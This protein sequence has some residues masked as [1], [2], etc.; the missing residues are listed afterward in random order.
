MTIDDRTGKPVVKTRADIERCFSESSEGKDTAFKEK[1]YAVKPLVH[2]QNVFVDEVCEP[3]SIRAHATPKVFEAFA[4]QYEPAEGQKPER[5]PRPRAMVDVPWCGER[6]DVWADGHMFLFGRA[7]RR[8][9]ADTRAECLRRARRKGSPY[10]EAGL[11][12]K[13]A[14]KA[15]QRRIEKQQE[16]DCPTGFFG[17]FEGEP[18]AEVRPVGYVCRMKV[19]DEF[20]GLSVVFDNHRDKAV[21]AA[22]RPLFELALSYIRPLIPGAERRGRLL[23]SQ[24]EG[25]ITK[26][27]RIFLKGWSHPGETVA[28]IEEVGPKGLDFPE[29]LVGLV[30]PVT[31][32]SETRGLWPKIPDSIKGAEAEQQKHGASSR[33]PAPEKPESEPQPKAKKA[34]Q[35]TLFE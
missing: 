26:P 8:A 10:R 19:A 34:R 20:G 35:A 25:S 11:A 7:A 23:L 27:I 6:I 33:S 12:E 30:M 3:P 4:G 28:K 31:P 5:F 22:R 14:E 29:S 15:E 17:E 9:F 21:A 24:P 1:L 16:K 2:P 13:E 32:S 18:R